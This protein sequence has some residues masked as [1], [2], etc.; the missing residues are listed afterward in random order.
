MA[1]L[2]TKWPPG[3]LTLLH[4]PHLH[5]FIARLVALHCSKDLKWFFIHV[6]LA[7]WEQKSLL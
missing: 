5:M 1:D 7:S 2:C 4:P 3:T 6:S